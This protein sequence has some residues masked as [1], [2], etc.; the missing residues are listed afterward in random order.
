MSSGIAATVVLISS[1]DN[2]GAG[3]MLVKSLI[4]PVNTG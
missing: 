3:S 4:G 2:G 1:C